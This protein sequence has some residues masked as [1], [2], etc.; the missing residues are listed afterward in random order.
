MIIM[1]IIM[2]MIM[3]MMI[4]T[5]LMKG[6]SG[7]VPKCASASWARGMLQRAQGKVHR[8]HQTGSHYVTH[9]IIM[10]IHNCRSMPRDISVPIYANKVTVSLVKL[11]L[12]HTMAKNV[13]MWHY[14]HLLTTFWLRCQKRFAQMCLASSA[15]RWSARCPSRLR[16]RWAMFWHFWWEIFLK[17]LKYKWKW[18]SW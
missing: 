12:C 4:L 14:H 6:C 10:M 1:I 9:M 17:T 8:C 18:Q 5:M 13:T 16:R 7:G 3:I 15:A 11:S 2:I